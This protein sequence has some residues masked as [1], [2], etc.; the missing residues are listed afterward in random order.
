MVTNIL[1][2]AGENSVVKVKLKGPAPKLKSIHPTCFEAGKP[3]EF[4]A[5][6][7]NLMQP[8]FRYELESHFCQSIIRLYLVLSKYPEFFINCQHSTG[9]IMIGTELFMDKRKSQAC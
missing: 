7:S 9:D 6:G 4:F 2:K 3:M 8:R 5:C 1:Y